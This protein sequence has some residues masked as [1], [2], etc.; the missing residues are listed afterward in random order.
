MMASHR[1]TR[2]SGVSREFICNTSLTSLS[3]HSS[4]VPMEPPLTA[5]P[6]AARVFPPFHSA[7]TAAQ[8]SSSAGKFQI[9][10]DYYRKV[11][12]TTDIAGRLPNAVFT[13]QP[14][15]VQ[16]II[17][18]AELSDATRKALVAMGKKFYLAHRQYEGS[19]V[20]IVDWYVVR[21]LI[22]STAA[23]CIQKATIALANVELGRTRTR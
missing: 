5:P 19:K 3:Q 13:L 6:P 16:A 4:P 7:A 1:A 11:D 22:T 9:S 10:S 2:Q 15:I 12:K 14:H 21:T 18:L 17:G 23:A 8:P 20:E